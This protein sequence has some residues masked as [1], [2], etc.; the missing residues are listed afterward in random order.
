M[1]QL[2]FVRHGETVLNQAGRWSGTINTP[3]TQK[4]HAQA[5]R[6][7][8][9]VVTRQLQFDLI[10]SSP[11]D[12]ALQT[13]EYIARAIEYPSTRIDVSELFIERGFGSLEGTPHRLRLDAHYALNEAAVD[14]YGGE[15]FADLQKRAQRAHE[16]L[17]ICEADSILVVAHSAFGRALFRAI[18]PKRRR[19]F[20]FK[21]GEIMQFL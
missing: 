7:G 20:Q 18:N 2:Y 19:R 11:L 12:R 21:N 14:K 15:P 5:E 17:Q 6:A 8:K 9:S 16:Y 10:I 1:K 13:A 3:L 4:G